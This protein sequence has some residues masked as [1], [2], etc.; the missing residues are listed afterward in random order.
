MIYELDLAQSF[1]TIAF[2]NAKACSA[3]WITLNARG[4]N[5]TKDA[6]SIYIRCLDK[7]VVSFHISITWTL[8]VRVTDIV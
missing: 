8:G 4:V 6:T 1:V 2:S 7:L 5:S 3:L